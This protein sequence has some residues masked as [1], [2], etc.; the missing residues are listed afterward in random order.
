MQSRSDA[1]APVSFTLQALGELKRVDDFF[2]YAEEVG[3]ENLLG[4]D[5]YIL[6]RPWVAPARRDP[7]FIRL[8][9]GIGLVDY[10][11]KSGIWPDFCREPDLP[12]DCK[13]EAAKLG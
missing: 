6:F 8:A 7:R 10:W 13:E 4:F 9:K 12:Y 11:Q 2:A 3:A 5:S 1:G